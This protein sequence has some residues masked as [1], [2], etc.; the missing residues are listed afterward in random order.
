MSVPFERASC[1]RNPSGMQDMEMTAR[2]SPKGLAQKG[3]VYTLSYLSYVSSLK[4]TH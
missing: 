1:N 2:K 4:V 3:Y